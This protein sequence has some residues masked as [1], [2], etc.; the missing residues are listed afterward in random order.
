MQ[1]NC[2]M[3]KKN[4][5]EIQT[6]VRSFGPSLR[7]GHIEMACMKAV[8]MKCRGTFLFVARVVNKGLSIRNHPKMV[9][10]SQT[11]HFIQILCQ[12]YSYFNR[13]KL[14]Y[15]LVKLTFE[16]NMDSIWTVYG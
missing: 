9:K 7:S 4:L 16:K 3:E 15:N 12:L 8:C 14:G 6:K 10:N 2:E 1:G 13:T 11:F 5:W